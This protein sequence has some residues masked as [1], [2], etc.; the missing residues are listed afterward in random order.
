MTTVIKSEQLKSTNYAYYE[1]REQILKKQLAI[2]FPV[3]GA[4]CLLC[5]FTY[6]VAD[7]SSVFTIAALTGAVLSYLLSLMNLRNGNPYILIWIFIGFSTA[8]CCYGFYSDNTHMVSNTIALTIP[9]LC[10]FSLRYKHAL[11]YSL[12]FGLIYI[13]LSIGEIS[14][15]E[16]Q[17]T[18]VLQNISSYTMIFIMAHLLARHRNEAISKVRKTATTDFLTGLKNRHGIENIY[19]NEAARCQ[20]YLRDFSMLLLDIDN[21]KNINDRYGLQAGDKVLMMVSNLLRDKIRQ[22]DHI[23]RLSSEEF[24]LLLPNT[25]ITQAEEMAT[26]LKDDIASCSL[27][28]ENGQTVTVTIS[29]GLTPVEYQEF[30]IDY[31]KADSALQ[32]AKNWGRNQV[33]VSQ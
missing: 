27:E 29:I 23:A 15:K 7:V 22:T 1:K 3:T 28:L 12:A 5:A 11:S 6:Y 4:I 16:Q 32:R 21:L 30:S 2:L 13:F 20:R 25:S 9:L 17:L 24:C 18:E 31:S 8:V 10:F 33:V 26:R 14:S 19:Q